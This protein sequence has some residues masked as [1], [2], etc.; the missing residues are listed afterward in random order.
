[1]ADIT[2]GLHIFWKSECS[3]GNPYENQNGAPNR[4]YKLIRVVVHG[5][6]YSPPLD[7]SVKAVNSWSVGDKESSILGKGDAREHN[8][9]QSAHPQRHT[10]LS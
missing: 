10:L 6:P 1:M 8:V 3:H 2:S 4:H 9:L 7:Q 5:E